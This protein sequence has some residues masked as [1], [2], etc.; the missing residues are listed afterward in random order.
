M[1]AGKTSQYASIDTKNSSSERS[2]TYI[3]YA[4]SG[5][6]TALD[7]TGSDHGIFTERLLRFMDSVSPWCM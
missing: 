5:D 1:T 2:N 3:I 7:G 4:T 6:R